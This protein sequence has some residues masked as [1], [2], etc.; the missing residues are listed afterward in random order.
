MF[1]ALEECGTPD[2]L[3]GLVFGYLYCRIRMRINPLEVFRR[4]LVLRSYLMDFSILFLDHIVD[5]REFLV[6]MDEG[7]ISSH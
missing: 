3:S 7:W 4:T 5:D 1:L 2:H 6:M